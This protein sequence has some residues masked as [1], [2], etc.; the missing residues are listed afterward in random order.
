M[1]EY[2]SRFRRDMSLKVHFSVDTEGLETEDDPTRHSKLYI[3]SKW[4]PDSTVA[5]VDERL[6]RFFN[7]VEKLFSKKKSKSNL[8]HY[9][10][11]LLATLLN[12]DSIVIALSD[13][14]LGPCAVKLVR[15]IKDALAHLMDEK[16]YRILSADEAL[17]AVRRIEFDIRAWIDKFGPHPKS[18]RE[19]REGD[20]GSIDEMSA[21]YI[22]QKTNESARKDPYAYFY[23]LYKLHKSPLK[24]RP[25]SSQCASVAFSIGQWVDEQLQPIAQS[26][27]SY[28]RDSFVLKKQLSQLNLPP[29][30]AL[31]SMD[32]TAMYTNIDSTA[33]LEVLSEYL[34]REEVRRKFGYNADCLI[35][36]IGI[37]LRSNVMKF[38]DIFVEQISGVAMGVAPAPPFAT[39]YYGIKEQSLLAKWGDN[40]F[41]YRRFIDD[42]FCIWKY[43]KCP[44][45]D[46]RKW[47]EMQADV[48]DFHGLQW[49]FTERVDSLN[50][51]DLV[52]YKEGDKLMTDLFEKPMALFLYL[53][54]HSSHPPGVL[55][56]LIFGQIL[57]IFSL[58]STEDQMK[59]H[60][61]N[62]FNRLIERGHKRDQLTP[63]FE[64]AVENAEAYL[65]LTEEER[66]E[67][68][69]A[70]RATGKSNIFFHVPYHPDNPST[71]A[72]QKLFRDCISAPLGKPPLE[73][74]RNLDGELI[75]VRGMTVAYHRHQ[76][77]GNILSYR[78]LDKRKGP[79]VSELLEVARRD[80]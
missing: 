41:Y 38:G 66:Q 80:E 33:C 52:I 34:R 46:E 36:A 44:I 31:F 39:I 75:Q 49:E 32:A 11:K 79:K 3:P 8:L 61:M 5:E 29:G 72:L 4:V 2:F 77:L 14:G 48:N 69:N 57:R 70:K 22:L 62:F 16:T 74:L 63:V 26:F 71:S 65:Q 43:D 60:M 15:Y 9:Q 42:V 53:P 30:V 56:G 64:K 19:R 40:F 18:Q 20:R 6:R 78:K 59:K 37:V 73:D 10:Q 13:K 23:L 35:E 50:F 21:L 76:N 54:P 51:M 28:F 7:E 47:Q 24:T 45:E 55:T 17:A 58:C 68:K 27:P 25:V 1:L 67:K 12:D